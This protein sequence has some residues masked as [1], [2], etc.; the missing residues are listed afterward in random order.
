MFEARQLAAVTFGT[1]GAALLQSE[2][3]AVRVGERV[4]RYV[5]LFMYLVYRQWYFPDM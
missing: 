4:Y 1:Q 2:S 3:L 5:L